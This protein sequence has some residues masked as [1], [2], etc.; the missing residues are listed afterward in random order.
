MRVLHALHRENFGSWHRCLLAGFSILFHGF[1]SKAAFLREFALTECTLGPIV[2]VKGYV[3]G[4]RMGKVLDDV[5]SEILGCGRVSFRSLQQQAEFIANA[6][7]GA[8]VAAGLSVPTPVVSETHR[9][10]LEG[11]EE[12]QAIDSD[13]DDEVCRGT[14]VRQTRAMTGAHN[15]GSS[16]AP[17]H[18]YIL[19]HNIEGQALRSKETQGA[20]AYL[21]SCDGIHVAGGI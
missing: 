9:L 13:E 12:D 15:G 2:E 4:M 10:E 11:G 19:V 21:A 7:R 14:E 17:T 20:L 18:L 3:A 6:V 16:G 1:G 5:T 8:R